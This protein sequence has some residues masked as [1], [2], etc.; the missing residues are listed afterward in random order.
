[1]QHTV[2]VRILHGIAEGNHERRDVAPLSRVVRAPLREGAAAGQLH[3]EERQVVRLIHTIDGQDAR[4]L[5]RRHRARL[6][7]KP[8]A[9][10]LLIRQPRTQ[11]FQSDRAVRLPLPGA[12][13]D[14]HAAARD[15]LQH[16][17]PWHAHRA[18]ALRTLRRRGVLSHPHAART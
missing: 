9:H 10:S 15:L 8:L 12:I 18:H 3:G 11:H 6:L 4:M 5:Q 16:V 1:M 13:H 14:A 2:L 17:V 7:T